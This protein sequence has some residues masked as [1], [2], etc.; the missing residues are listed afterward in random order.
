METTSTLKS[1]RKNVEEPMEKKKSWE[2]I[3]VECR[4]DK[5][6]SFK[7]NTLFQAFQS[8]YFQFLLQDDPSIEFSKVIYK[9]ISR[10]RLHQVA[11]KMPVLPCH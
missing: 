7:W 10:S 8:K 2:F 5:K 9:N 4:V 1:K 11:A 6:T 3:D